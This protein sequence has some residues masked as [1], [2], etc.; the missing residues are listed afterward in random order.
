MSTFRE[1]IEAKNEILERIGQVA[2][3]EEL[4]E[5]LQSLQARHPLQENEAE[6]ADEFLPMTG[7]AYDPLATEEDELL[8]PTRPSGRSWGGLAAAALLLVALLG[9]FLWFQRPSP[10]SE[11]SPPP[12]FVPPPPAENAGASVLE[13]PDAPPPAE[14][15][16][17]EEMP[18]E[19]PEPTPEPER[20]QVAEVQEL[21]ERAVVVPV[22]AEA[23]PVPVPARRPVP[24][25]PPAE[26]MAGALRPGPGVE[27]P[28]P[29]ELPA[30][31]FPSAARGQGIRIDV[32]LDLLVDEQGRVV[33]ALVREGDTSGLGFNEAAVNAAKGTRFQ[34]ATRWD[35]PGK[36]WTELIIEFE[37][38]SGGAPIT[39]RGFG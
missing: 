21:P 37:E 18:A 32:H 22:V 35:L 19:E 4:A 6:I 3:A 2:S 39:E 24:F 1:S 34:P 12:S 23:R 8:G 15:E 14:P 11:P 28:V 7:P 5:I 20:V 26:R 30:V 33:E 38:P 27:M 31:R 25:G 16:I 29:L 17:I 36:A 10:T 13:E 9:G